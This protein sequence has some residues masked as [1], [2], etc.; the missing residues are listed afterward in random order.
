MIDFTSPT[1]RALDDYLRIELSKLR[2]K[3]DS[4]K[5]SS[6]ETASIRGRIAQIQELLSLPRNQDANAKMARPFQEED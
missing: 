1:W 2:S 4:I 6:D 3:N 5:L